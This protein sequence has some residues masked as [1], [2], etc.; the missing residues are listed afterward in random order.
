MGKH[1]NIRPKT[2]AKIAQELE[3]LPHGAK[4]ERLQAYL[5]QFDMEQSTFYRKLRKARLTEANP[6]AA[7]PKRP[8]LRTWTMAIHALAT[9]PPD[10]KTVPYVDALAAAVEAGLVPPEAALVHVETFHRIARELGLRDTERKINCVEPDHA[11][12]VVLTDA[13]GSAYFSVVKKLDDGD[14][15]LRM[16]PRPH[17]D[18][19]NKPLLNKERLRVIA[20]GFWEMFSG[21]T[22]YTYTVSMGENGPDA[23]EAF[24]AYMNASADPRNPVYGV[25][26]ELWSDQGPVTK[27]ATAD[28]IERL[29]I[30]LVKG[31]PYVKERMGGVEQLWRRAWEAERSYYMQLTTVDGKVQPVEMTLSELNA[32]TRTRIAQSNTQPGSS[33][34][35]PAKSKWQAWRESAAKRG[36][37]RRLPDHAIETLATEITRTVDQHGVITWDK[38]E[39]EVEDGLHSCKVIARRSLA[40]RSIVTVEDIETGRKYA[41]K[42]F[43]PRKL[44]EFRAF[45]KSNL[46]MAKEIGQG[47]SAPSPYHPSPFAQIPPNPPF[48]KGG[49]EQPATD[50][51]LYQRG[52]GGISNIIAMPQRT[53][54]AEPLSNPLDASRHAT[55]GEALRAFMEWHG[56]P[57][58]ATDFPDVFDQCVDLI[59]N[60]YHLN[61]D[62]VRKLALDI[63]QTLMPSVSIYK[64]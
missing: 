1:R 3:A 9:K 45:P 14:Y 32:R 22:W 6:R 30:K 35:D 42:P 55:K 50:T 52:A 61:K 39:Y 19:K 38:Q 20:Y 33:R 18:Y 64:E 60:H 40:D 36:G 44:G 46:D 11:H 62:D 51:P 16:N 59:D 47:I 17:A 57:N 8:E 29:G 26:D 34:F 7:A 25:P 53:K 48:S 58:F 24:C 12:Q 4:G 49:A 21:A 37:I 54:P 31:E 13:S 56:I 28:L 5:E 63:R 10:G 2:L 41:T 27:G 43:E 23:M 15:L